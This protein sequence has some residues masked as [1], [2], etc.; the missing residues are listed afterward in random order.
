MTQQLSKMDEFQKMKKEL[1]Q[2][3]HN[4]IWENYA[5]GLTYKFQNGRDL[6]ING[7][8]HFNYAITIEENRIIL[9]LSPNGKNFFIELKYGELIYLHD[10]QQ[11]FELRF[12][13]GVK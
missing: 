10:G 1:E 2:A 3:V 5:Y 11:Q 6:W 9:K 4:S 8:A 12:R 7:N 13:E